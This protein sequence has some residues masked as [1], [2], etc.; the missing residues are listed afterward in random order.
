VARRARGG[1][2]WTDAGRHLQQAATGGRLE[3]GLPSFILAQGIIG[4]AIAKTLLR[5]ISG[6]IDTHWRAFRWRR[7]VRDCSERHRG[8]VDNPVVRACCPAPRQSGD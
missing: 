2:A 8:M 5:V 4:C 6:E 7:A 3:I 1:A